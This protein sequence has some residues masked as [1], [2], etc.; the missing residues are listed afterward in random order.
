M[1]IDPTVPVRIE[2]WTFP[3]VGTVLVRPWT[4]GNPGEWVR[5]DVQR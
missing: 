4:N 2:K 3:Q 5:K 1:S